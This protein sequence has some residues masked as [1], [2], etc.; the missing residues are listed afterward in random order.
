MVSGS[1]RTFDDKLIL[2]PFIAE[3]DEEFLRH[4]YMASRG[5]LPAV[6]PDE[7]E[8]Q[9]F[10]EL[11]YRGQTLTYATEFPDASHSIIELDGRYFARSGI[12]KPWDRNIP[13]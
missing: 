7:N 12:S 11:Q 1:T 13:S 5:D 8:Q 9:R 2:R 3:Q 10:L 4:L 6:F